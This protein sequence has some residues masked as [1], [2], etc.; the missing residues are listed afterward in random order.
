MKPSLAKGVDDIPPRKQ[1]LKGKIL[2]VIRSN[3]KRYGFNPL[4]TPTI[5]R[6]DVLTSKFAGG[7]EILKE[8]Y[9]FKDQG[10]R[11][12][13]LRYDLTV[14]LARFISLNRDLKMPFKR[15]QIGQVFRDGPIKAGRFREFTQ[16]DG[17]VVGS[18][19]MYSDAE[20]LK[21]ASSVFN[22]LNIDVE[23]KVNNRKFLD[24]L[25]PVEDKASFILSLDK[26]EKIGGKGVRKELLGKGFDEKDVEF[27]LKNL[28]LSYSELKIKFKESFSELDELL[29]YCKFLG[30]NVVFTPSLARGLSYYT[31]T[32]F[33][34]FLKDSKMTGSIAAGGRYDNMISEFAGVE[35]P[36]VGISFGLDAL[37]SALDDYKEES[38]TKV[39]VISIDQDREAIKV[40]QSL[41]SEGVYCDFNLK[42]LKKGLNFAAS[43]KIPYCLIIGEEEVN[44]KKYTLRDMNSGK[45]KKLNLK[46]I[47]SV[48]KSK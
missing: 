9:S 27:V 42:N 40:M 43:Y 38:L 12:L 34:V 23:I 8:V 36:A 17:D 5:E 37:M 15:Y 33:E 25:I 24:A 44:L 14:G 1:I 28:E 7:E 3:F 30:V 20:L 39:Y 45:E 31:G 11:E 6:L 2:R 21:M 29:N 10:Q 18:S 22:E 46:E 35:L 48:L 4:Q 19:S 41:R 13:G 32:V 47:V 26:L 16:C